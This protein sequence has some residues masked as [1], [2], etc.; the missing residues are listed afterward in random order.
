MGLDNECS[1]RRRRQLGQN[2][3]PTVANGKV[4]MT[5][6]PNEELLALDTTEAFTLSLPAPIERRVIGGK[7]LFVGLCVRP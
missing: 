3:S 1:S 5:S 6:F 4:Y 7:A 2:N